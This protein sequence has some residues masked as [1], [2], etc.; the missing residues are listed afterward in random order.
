VYKARTDQ[1][2]ILTFG[3]Y[4]VR[5]HHQST[6]KFL[7]VEGVKAYRYGNADENDSNTH[8]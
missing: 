4:Q 5:I 3:F 8:K 1:P 2:V 7:F 6:L